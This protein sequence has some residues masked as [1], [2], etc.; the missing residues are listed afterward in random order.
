MIA[1]PA[2][3]QRGSAG[4]RRPVAPYLALASTTVVLGLS[5]RS[6][7]H[8]FPEVIARYGGDAL[9]AALVVWLCAL[10][11]RS[12]APHAVA[13]MAFAISV[14][15][16][17]SQLSRAPWL[18]AIRA[19]PVGALVLGQGF[20]WSDILCYLTGVACALALDAFLVRAA[21]RRQRQ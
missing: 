5:T 4:L 11:R 21:R 6:A 10:W 13:M 9:W 12:A 14:A 18:E 2:T 7:P 19:T 20:L 15:V 16:E 1:V 8:L 17:S 3:R